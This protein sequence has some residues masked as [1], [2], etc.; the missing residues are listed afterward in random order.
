MSSYPAIPAQQGKLERRTLGD[1]VYEALCVA[2]MSGEFPPSTRLT[3]RG[4]ADRMGT[5]AMPV[6]EA[7]HR[8]SGEGLLEPLPN[9]MT[10]VPVLDENKL[11]ELT[12]IRLEVEGLA[13]ARAAHRM[14]RDEQ[15]ALRRADEQIRASFNAGDTLGEVRGNEQFHFALYHAARSREL[16]RIIQRLWLQVGPF[17]LLYVTAQNNATAAERRQNAQY[18]GS[19]FHHR[20]I[21][22]VENKD[23]QGA[24]LALQ[25]DIQQG[26]DFL[27]SFSRGLNEEKIKR[28][29]NAAQHA[30]PAGKHE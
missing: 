16:L 15:D 17:L 5:S 20:I 26:R 21:A 6:R 2:L 13:A 12:E 4:L 30:K 23:A 25:E 8:L 1:G 22:A 18:A 29:C 28:I 24:R 3:V 19:E 10:R 9:G 27:R 11:L 7:L 14:T